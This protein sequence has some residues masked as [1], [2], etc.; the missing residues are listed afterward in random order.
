MDALW[1][2]RNKRDTRCYEDRPIERDL[3]EQ[4]I[5]AGRMAGSA[6]NLQPV[7]MVVVSDQAAKMAL[8]AAGDFADWIDQAP[9]VIVVTVQEFAGP[10][11]MFDVGRHSQNLMVAAHAAGVASCPVTIHH[12]EV[13]RAALGIPN[14][15]DPAMIVT[16]GW[17][18][19][20]R[21]PSPVAGPRVPLD[22][23]AS[24]DRWS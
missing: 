16:L 19:P 7:R 12:P 17:P 13:A 8:K 5:D 15:V 24:W 11:R 18:A 2:L 21:V 14:D 1:A 3:L 9:V 6:K 10:R 23:Y 22:E 4:L 20:S